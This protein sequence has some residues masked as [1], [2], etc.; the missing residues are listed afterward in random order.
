MADKTFDQNLL[1]MI[2]ATQYLNAGLTVAREMF[3][4]S[5]FSLGVSEKVAV[6]Q[7][8]FQMVAANYQMINPEWLAGQQA[9]QPVGFRAPNSGQSGGS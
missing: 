5:Y 9:Q 2:A 6:D 8:V 7:A 4:K 1:R 3:G